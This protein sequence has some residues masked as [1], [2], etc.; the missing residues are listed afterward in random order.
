[1]SADRS[2][3]GPARSALAQ[4][5]RAGSVDHD[6]AK[7]LVVVASELLANAIAASPGDATVALRGTHG[8]GAVI[9]E[10]INRVSEWVSPAER[11]DLGDP[12]RTGGRGLLI[13]SALVDHI[14]AEHDVANFCTVVRVR[15]GLTS[16]Q[17]HDEADCAEIADLEPALRI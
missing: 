7:D 8:S 1:M 11:W 9:L 2:E 16:M 10:A 3:I 4:W 6:A 15:R 5:L 17:R 14:E 12:L 13:V